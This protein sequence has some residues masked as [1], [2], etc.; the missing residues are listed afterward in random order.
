M[1]FSVHIIIKRMTLLSHPFLFVLFFS[2]QVNAQFQHN[3]IVADNYKQ[4]FTNEGITVTHLLQNATKETE[5]AFIYLSG[6][7]YVA[8]YFIYARYDGILDSLRQNNKRIKQLN[9]KS[10]FGQFYLGESY[11]HLGLIQMAQNNKLGALIA[12]KKA[13]NIHLKNT[14][15]PFNFYGRDKTLGALEIVFSEAKNYSEFSGLLTTNTVSR[16]NGEQLLNHAISLDPLYQFEAQI[17]QVLLYQFVIYDAKSAS[18]CITQ[19][20]KTNQTSNLVKSIAAIIYTKN[21]DS[22]QALL[23]LEH[24]NQMNPYFIYLQGINNL[25]LLNHKKAASYLES[26][27]AT[28]PSYYQTSARYFLAE[29]YYLTN[30]KKLSQAIEAVRSSKQFDL[31]ADKKALSKIDGL[32]LQNKQLV[33]VRLLFDGGA[34]Q[35]ALMQINKIDKSSLTSGV[36]IEYYYRL[37]RIYQELERYANAKSNFLMVVFKSPSQDHTY[38][39]PYSCLQLAK[40]FFLEKN[41]LKANQYLNS[42]LIYKNYQHQNSIKVQLNKMSLLV[43]EQNVTK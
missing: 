1:Y 6:L 39:A 42:G 35:E 32:I 40:I 13:Y 18:Q 41:T 4:I 20:L 28:N 36:I 33:K 27:L 21:N 19:L 17:F 38:F 16:K 34:Y 25:Q 29:C 3:V 8:D 15:L 23:V 14:N 10:P 2:A 31:P 5:G 11:F 30:S 22:K 9:P 37:A 12:L 43:N 26:F 7:K 24:V